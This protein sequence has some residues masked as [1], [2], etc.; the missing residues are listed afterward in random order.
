MR[1]VAHTRRFASSGSILG[2]ELSGLV[3]VESGALPEGCVNVKVPKDS[4]LFEAAQAIF[5][6]GEEGLEPP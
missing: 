1:F 2:M 4:K 6:T 5:P 3:G